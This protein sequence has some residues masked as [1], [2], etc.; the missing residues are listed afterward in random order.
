MGYY[1]ILLIWRPCDL[2]LPRKKRGGSSKVV[3]A[4]SKINEEGR[5]LKKI[6]KR[7]GV[8]IWKKNP[9]SETPRLLDRWDTST[10]DLILKE[11]K[12]QLIL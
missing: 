10:I 12:G 3:I 9:M 11:T 2:N 1:L 4:I 7:G 6:N 8:E 5:I